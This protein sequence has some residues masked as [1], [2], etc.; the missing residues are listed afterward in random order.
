MKKIVIVLVSI[1]TC[2]ALQAQYAGGGVPNSAAIGGQNNSVS[3]RVFAQLLGSIDDAENKR[4][5][6]DLTS[7]QGSPYTSNEFSSTTLFYGDD[8]VRD[9]YYRYNALNEE[10]E[11]KKTF[12]PN[13]GFRGLS[14]DKNINI[15]VDGNKLSFN[16]FITSKNKTLNGYLAELYKGKEYTLYKRIMVKF[17]EGEDAQNSFIAAKPARFTQ[18]T[19]YYFKKKGVNRIDQVLQKN[20]KILKQIEGDMASDMKSHISENNL[21]V[22]NEADLVAVFQFLDKK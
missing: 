10:I 9:V 17:T 8:K 12:A 18:F 22:K 15:I 3:A 11:V 2:G 19:E 20:S 16:T 5:E 13:E 21:N 14:R 6:I 4:M 7:I 1:F